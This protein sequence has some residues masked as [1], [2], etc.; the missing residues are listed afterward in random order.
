[1]GRGGKGAMR[2]PGATIRTALEVPGLLIIDFGR[3]F[4]L[5]LLDHLAS[6][7]EK[8]AKRQTSPI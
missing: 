8:T 4:Q 7:L 2:V 6:I 3:N 5:E 1:M